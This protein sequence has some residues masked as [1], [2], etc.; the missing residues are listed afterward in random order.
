MAKICNRYPKTLGKT[1]GQYKLKISK[2]GKAIPLDY[3]MVLPS[4]ITDKIKSQTRKKMLVGTKFKEE[5][6]ARQKEI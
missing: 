1:F 4:R 2:E 6:E 5:F 3:V